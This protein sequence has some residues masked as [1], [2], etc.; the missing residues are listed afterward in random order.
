MTVRIKYRTIISINI[1][2]IATRSIAI[3]YIA[4]GFIVTTTTTMT[5]INSGRL[6]SGNIR[7]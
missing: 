2:I 4:T 7:K 3:A 1:I 6:V 5:T